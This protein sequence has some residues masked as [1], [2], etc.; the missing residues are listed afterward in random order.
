MLGRKRDQVAPGGGA[1][2]PNRGGG[3]IRSVLGEL[4]HLG[5]RDQIDQLLGEL[6]L[7]RSGTGEVGPVAHRL[8]DR[9]D[10]PWISV[11]KD[12]RP[13]THAPVDELAP[14]GIPHAAAGAAD[15]KAR[16]VGRKLVV[17]LAVGVATPPGM[18]RRARSPRLSCSVVDIR[19]ESKRG[20]GRFRYTASPTVRS[21][22]CPNKC[23]DPGRWRPA[24]RGCS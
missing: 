20:R 2:E 17:A 22:D 4:D 9:V 24:C 23:F 1:G 13:Q 15:D 3:D 16:R 6:A 10:H 14:V 19:P 7:D 18:A 21:L 11:A 8:D 12:H 5:A